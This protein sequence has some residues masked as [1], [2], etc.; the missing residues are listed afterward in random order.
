LVLAL[1][2]VYDQGLIKSTIKA[3]LLLVVYTIVLV[4]GFAVLF[5]AAVVLL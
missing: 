2:H 1:A 4:I 5:L 3:F